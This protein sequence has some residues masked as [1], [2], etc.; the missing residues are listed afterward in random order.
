MKKQ[1]KLHF[2]F[3]TGG[4]ECYF[5]DQIRL[6]SVFYISFSTIN[7]LF[8]KIF[9]NGTQHIEKTE[10]KLIRRKNNIQRFSNVYV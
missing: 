8:F 4:N 7:S 10:S 6:N 3:K 1:F 9:V 2:F 5:D